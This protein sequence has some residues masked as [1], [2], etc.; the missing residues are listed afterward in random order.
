MGL[1]NSHRS[2]GRVQTTDVHDVLDVIPSDVNISP[3]DEIWDEIWITL[4]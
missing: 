3:L 1:K 4:W 2:P